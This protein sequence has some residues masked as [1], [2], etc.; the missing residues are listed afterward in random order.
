MVKKTTRV[1]LPL[2]ETRAHDQIVPLGSLAYTRPSYL[3]ISAW[4]EHV[5][6]AFWL[7]EAIRPSIFVELGTH[8]GVSYFAFCQAME[9][10]NLGAQAFAVDMW[11]GDE[12][13]G[14]YGPEVLQAVATHNDRAYSHFS[15]LKKSKFDDALGYFLDGSIDLLHIDGLH[16]Y[17]AVKHDFENWLPKMSPR[18]VVVF[19]DTNV[20]E[21]DFGVFRLFAELKQT[22]PTFEFSH[23]HGLG[24]V[25][26]GTELAEKMHHLFDAE[27]RDH[28]R[29]D[30][31]T[32]FSSLGRGCLDTYKARA[33]DQNLAEVR[34]QLQAEIA[35]H[36]ESA[37]QA[38]QKVVAFA[39][40]I[41]KRTD[42]L[43]VVTSA[44]GELDSRIKQLETDMVK[45]QETAR[46]AE[47][48]V[49]AL[50][51]DLEQRITEVQVAT[52][53]RIDADARAARSNELQEQQEAALRVLETEASQSRLLIQES[54]RR[55]HEL[56]AKLD[57]TDE[58]LQA[59]EKQRADT[60]WRRSEVEA[61]AAERERHLLLLED[62]LIVQRQSVARV[63][64]ELETLRAEI[65]IREEE[66][67]A[68]GKREEELR[69][70]LTKTRSALL[71]RE[72]ETEQN[73]MELANLRSELER[74]SQALT[75][76][77]KV[78]VGFKDH[79]A[80]LIAD[81]KQHQATAAIT[82]KLHA[83]RLR[84]A[85]E[86]L[87]FQ[88]IEYEKNADELRTAKS[89]SEARLR[90]LREA[91]EARVALEK[92]HAAEQ[93]KHAE[94]LLKEKNDG[95]TRLKLRFDEIANLT[96]LLKDAEA[97]L[98]RE[99]GQLEGGPRDALG[100]QSWETVSDFGT[101]AGL[102]LGRA[103]LKM[104]ELPAIWKVLPAGRRLKHQMSLLRRSGLFDAEWYLSE[105]RDVAEAGVDPSQHYI[106]YGA[107][108]GRE[109][110]GTLTTRRRAVKAG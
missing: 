106:L 27:R 12:H 21:R 53:A 109:P 74:V 5:P 86:R 64:R 88:A 55:V 75:E 107:R 104:I 76:R 44:R 30:L 35:K 69:D 2:K 17:D 15:T 82:E 79:V 19:H 77:D 37:K 98:E 45:H 16:T 22:Y 29:R 94:E 43:Q 96:R 60:E 81:V 3:A 49:T 47:R 23:G 102:E 105:Y 24:V 103:I 99:A 26:V 89:E 70:E 92:A 66:I 100:R 71:Q 73:A 61:L 65:C 31:Q 108:E 67:K 101:S 72:H 20:R 78:L 95:E 56:Q 57:H 87:N 38:E 8:Y 25:G 10:L 33:G 36:Q 28:D 91:A 18:G 68:A 63:E 90:Q 62:Q 84:E 97:A 50:T 13:S 1:A 85:E 80:L 4:T 41:Q 93:A 6:F 110:N 40:D 52:S 39:A 58:V 46:E 7:I 51:A 54:E 9:K 83:K 32:L 48:K 11:T 59:T 34:R 42:E 14:L